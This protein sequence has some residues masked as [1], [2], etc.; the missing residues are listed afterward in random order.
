MENTIITYLQRHNWDEE[1]AIDAMLAR[2]DD[3]PGEQA[4][5][6]TV[7]DHGQQAQSSGSEGILAM[8]GEEEESHER[9]PN[10][11]EPE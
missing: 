3:L 5:S 6:S 10:E 1:Q 2:Q 4:E 9:S 7:Q 8:N 11:N